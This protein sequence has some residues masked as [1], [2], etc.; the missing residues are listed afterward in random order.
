MRAASPRAAGR[1]PRPPRVVIHQ[2]PTAIDV[3]G[4]VDEQASGGRRRERGDLP[5]HLASNRERHATGREDRERRARR[6]QGRGHT[7]DV[8][9]Q[10][11]A[12]VDDEES[13]PLAQE[14]DRRLQLAQPGSG[15]NPS[16]CTIVDATAPASSRPAS[17]THHTPPGKLPTVRAAASIASR[18]L[19]TP[20]APV[21]VSRRAD[22]TVATTA[23]RSDSRPTNVVS[24]AGR[25]CGVSFLKSPSPGS[26]LKDAVGSDS[27][28]EE[29]P[30]RVH[31]RRDL[32]RRRSGVRLTGRLSRPGSASCSRT[33]PRRS[34]RARGRSRTP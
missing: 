2:P 24:C 15:C 23:S 27:F 25:L 32:A 28:R 4:P 5:T 26:N 21:S 20:P 1:S 33:R 9:D 29:P 10:V 14:R 17:S 12:V 34:G 6:Q 7:G 30:H 18:V 11:L 19:P 22:G 13:L 3:P 16:V 8:L 31:R